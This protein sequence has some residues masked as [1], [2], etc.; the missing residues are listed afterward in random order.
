LWYPRIIDET[1]GKPELRLLML[2]IPQFMEEIDVI[3]MFIKEIDIEGIKPMKC[4]PE[5]ISRERKVNS[6]CLRYRFNIK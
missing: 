4:K 6:L 1:L 3:R 2:Q 5:P